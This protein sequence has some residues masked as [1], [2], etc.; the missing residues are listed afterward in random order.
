MAYD[1]PAAPYT[2]GVSTRGATLCARHEPPVTQTLNLRDIREPPPRQTPC[3]AEVGKML[4]LWMLEMPFLT[5]GKAAR[6]AG[7]R[8]FGGAF[9]VV[10]MEA[11]VGIEPT[12]EGF[13]DLSLPTWVPR[14]GRTV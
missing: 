6:L 3:N 12:N 9:P 1:H 8:G 14:L 13:A 2:R 11:R 7:V 4:I 5:A 10:K